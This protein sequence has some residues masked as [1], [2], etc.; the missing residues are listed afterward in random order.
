MMNYSKLKW[1]H[2]GLIKLSTA[3][4]VLMIAKAWPPLL[5]ADLYVYAAIFVLAALIPIF[6]VFK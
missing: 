1:Y 2:M 4:F 5:S 6:K 3:A